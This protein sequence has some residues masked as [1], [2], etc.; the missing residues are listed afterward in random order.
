MKNTATFFL[1]LLSVVFASV[2]I[3]VLLM[4]VLKLIMVLSTFLFGFE[5]E[6][7][8]DPMGISVFTHSFI[9]FFVFIIAMSK[10]S[11]LHDDPS[12]DSK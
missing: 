9:L 11:I 8:D 6:P 5:Y 10:L 12:R 4:F 7:I 1:G 3:L 2:A